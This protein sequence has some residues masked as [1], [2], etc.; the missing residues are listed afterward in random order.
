LKGAPK[1]CDSDPAWQDFGTVGSDGSLDGRNGIVV[2][3]ANNVSV[4]NLTSCNFLAG[5]GESGNEIWWNGGA[6]SGTVGLHGYTGRYLTATSTFF[7]PDGTVGNA[8]TTAAQ[9]G[10]FSSNSSGGVWD[11]IYA[12]NFNDSGSYVGAC[13][14]VCNVT[15]SHAWMEYDAL[16]YS[17]TNSGGTVVIEGSQFD[18]NKDGLD[19][20]T[21]IDGDPP[22][23]Q[24]GACPGTKTSPLTHTHSCWV[25]VD[26]YV[27]NNNDANVPEAGAASNGPTGTG[28]TLSGGTNDTVMDN[29]FVN[30]GAWG[31]LFVPYPDENAAVDGQ[32]CSKTGGNAIAGFGCVYD[33]KGDALTHN[34]FANDG[35]FGNP[36]NADFGELTLSGSEPQNCFKA[37]VAPQGS[38][39]ANL[40]TAQAK[41]GSKTKKANADPTLF[42][43]VLCDTGFGSCPAGATYPAFTGVVMHPLPAL[44]TMPNPCAGVPSNAWCKSGKPI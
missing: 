18:N 1:P 29:R 25:F 16:G 14:Q 20:N 33:P 7:G 24:D 13:Q 21:Q 39:P 41:C 44:A 32:S 36:S 15:I 17:G 3:K 38:V 30:N 23:P 28:M 2:W 5:T 11:Q 31:V 42:A 34:T 37:N 35:Y 6:E 19:T 8:E 40:E 43:Q 12:S 26:N 10:I 22:A 9:Y 27:H 4:E